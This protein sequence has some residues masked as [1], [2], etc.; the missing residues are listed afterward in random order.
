MKNASC[1]VFLWEAFFVHT[2][3][4][5][6]PCVMACTL[7]CQNTKLLFFRNQESNEHILRNIACRVHYSKHILRRCPARSSHV[8]GGFPTQLHLPFSSSDIFSSRLPPLISNFCSP[9]VSIIPQNKSLRNH[10][11][12]VF[13]RRIPSLISPVMLSLLCPGQATGTQKH[14]ASWRR[15]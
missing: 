4:M 9:T 13:Q 12:D 11:F 7:F 10:M 2:K 15:K 3:D 5:T 14:P 1:R 6:E 8:G